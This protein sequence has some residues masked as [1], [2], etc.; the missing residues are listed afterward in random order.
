MRSSVNRFAS[1]P[2][3][4]E[5]KKEIQT[6]IP[7]KPAAA[8]VPIVKKKPVKSVAQAPQLLSSSL[9]GYKQ[10]RARAEQA[11]RVEHFGSL[12]G[13]TTTLDLFTKALYFERE[14]LLRHWDGEYFEPGYEVV[15]RVPV[16]Q[17]LPHQTKLSTSSSPAFALLPGTFIDAFTLCAQPGVD[18][19]LYDLKH[20]SQRD[21]YDA[22]VVAFL[23]TLTA[24]LAAC[25]I[26]ESVG[27]YLS[28]QSCVLYRKVGNDRERH[29]AKWAM[30]SPQPQLLDASDEQSK[31]VHAL[32]TESIKA[33]PR[34][35]CAF[36]LPTTAAA[37][38]CI[39]LSFREAR[40]SVYEMGQN[41]EMLD[42][43]GQTCDDETFFMRAMSGVSRALA[44]HSIACHKLARIAAS[45]R[46][47]QQQQA[48]T[49]VL[50]VEEFPS[51]A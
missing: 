46:K 22:H 23:E 3:D 1:L 45:K 30:P 51:L 4:E 21:P 17:H 15:L 20:S 26:T 19:N 2:F 41:S 37:M 7:S 9:H 43:Y 44:T 36:K 25:G 29:M 5:D 6:C 50:R 42:C 40:D 10:E 12:K 47:Q 28:K 27:D 49:F 39:S 33:G 35:G 32:V 31:R 48:S 16:M 34:F 18:L 11:R 38:E 8:T 13:L 24:T 14:G